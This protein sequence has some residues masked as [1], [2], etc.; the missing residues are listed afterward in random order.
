M[1]RQTGAVT[2]TGKFGNMVGYT[3]EG[4]H[5]VR[6][7][8]GQTK[9][10]IMSNPRT[11]ANVDEFGLLQASI[12]ALRLGLIRA[13]TKVRNSKLQS[14]LSKR[15]TVIRNTSPEPK[16]ERTVGQGTNFGSLQDFRLSKRA[17]TSRLAINL[18]ASWNKAGINATLGILDI[19]PN[20][21]IFPPASAAKFS[22]SFTAAEFD[23]AENKVIASGAVIHIDKQE[24]TS[25]TRIPGASVGVGLAG[26]ANS[27]IIGATVI[28]FFDA[29][30]APLGLQENAAIISLAIQN[31]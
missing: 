21:D 4:S 2:F 15:L 18:N 26:I 1:G 27:H 5:L 12:S 23:L 19:T 22:L 11:K 6:T 8:G 31:V 29:N 13:I 20:V 7:P 10:Q 30:D 9:A 16:G 3:S 17:I 24:V 25:A 14:Q 28:E